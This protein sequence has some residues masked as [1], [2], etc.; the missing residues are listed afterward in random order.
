MLQEVTVVQFRAT[1][2][3]QT[4]LAQKKKKNQLKIHNFPALFATFPGHFKIFQ[5]TVSNSRTF[6]EVIN[7][8]FHTVAITITI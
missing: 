8:G 1:S 5:K 6:Y 3:E 7:D 2:E 4:G